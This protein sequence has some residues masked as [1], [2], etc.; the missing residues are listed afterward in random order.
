[1]LKIHTL[2]LKIDFQD[3]PLNKVLI[4]IIEEAN[5]MNTKAWMFLMLISELHLKVT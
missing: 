1:M 5:M 4:D 2:W 3:S